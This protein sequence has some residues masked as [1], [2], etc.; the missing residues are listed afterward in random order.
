MVT[1]S[2]LRKDPA[3]NIQIR[4]PLQ[5]G[6]AGSQEKGMGAKAAC[7]ALIAECL[8]VQMFLASHF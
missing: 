4:F 2:F 6:S 1:C 5:A 3:G 7:S 8:L